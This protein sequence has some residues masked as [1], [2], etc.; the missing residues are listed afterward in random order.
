M[1]NPRI[2]ARCACGEVE[3][4]AIGPP[5]AA[6]IC[7]CDDCQ[8]AAAR[9]EAMP[10]APAFR[11]PDGGTSLIVFREDRVRCVRGEANLKKL[12]VRE[13]SPTNRKLATC[14][15]SVM[16][17]DFDDAKHW[18]DIYSARVKENAP[19]PEMLVCTKFAAQPPRNV[20]ALPAYRGYA[21]HLL[22][23]L[24]KARIA[25]LFSR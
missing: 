11:E 19:E 15:N 3:I 18:A 22:I 10:G 23:R 9:I 7:Y 1:R 2:T 21:P 6:T 4:E 20:R 25:M 14:C 8:T 16:V 17:L 24:L 5:I 12:K 13:D